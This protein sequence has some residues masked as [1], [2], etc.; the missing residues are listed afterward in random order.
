L[1]PQ[2]RDQ[3]GDDPQRG[4]EM[5]LVP[6][7]WLEKAIGVPGIPGGLRRQDRDVGRRDVPGKCDD[8]LGAAAAPMKGDQGACR[9]LE[10]CSSHEHAL[11]AVRVLRRFRSRHRTSPSGPGFSLLHRRR[12]IASQAAVCRQ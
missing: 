9:R 10:R 8:V 11:T 7:H 3:V 2:L 12:I 6:F 1:L 5:R 4:R